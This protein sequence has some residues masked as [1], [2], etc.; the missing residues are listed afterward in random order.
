M[1]K[2]TTMDAAEVPSNNTATPEKMRDEELEDIKK[3]ESRRANTFQVRYLS[4]RSLIKRVHYMQ[5]PVMLLGG[6]IKD[7]RKLG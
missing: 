1:K 6:L 3:R 4:I 5:K 7:Q 2:S